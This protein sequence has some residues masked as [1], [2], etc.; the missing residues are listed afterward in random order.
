LAVASCAICI[1]TVNQGRGGERHIIQMNVILGTLCFGP[2]VFAFGAPV[3][4]I[5]GELFAI[6]RGSRH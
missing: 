4:G 1:A 3:G 6:L 5:L 2:F